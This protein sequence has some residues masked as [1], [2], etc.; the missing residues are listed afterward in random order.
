MFSLCELPYFHIFYI[1][2][3]CKKQKRSK[4]YYTQY[5]QKPF[6]CSQH[7]QCL[8]RSQ[9]LGRTLL[10]NF[11][12]GLELPPSNKLLN[13]LQWILANAPEEGMEM[14]RR[15]DIPVPKIKFIQFPISYRILQT[16]NI[17]Q[18]SVIKSISVFFVYRVY[19]SHLKTVEVDFQFRSMHVSLSQEY[20][21]LTKDKWQV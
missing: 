10:R 15:S 9:A 8:H 16:Q 4:C 13:H 14:C 5:R 7:L 18:I 19:V 20:T 2:N 17:P 6:L 21:W 3:L 1:C 12:A 11:P